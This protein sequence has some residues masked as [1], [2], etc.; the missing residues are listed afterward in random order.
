MDFI[1]YDHFS[2]SFKVHHFPNKTSFKK[3]IHLLRYSFYL[4]LLIFFI[5]INMRESWVYLWLMGWHV[6]VNARLIWGLKNKVIFL[7]V[8]DL[9]K[10]FFLFMIQNRANI[11]VHACIFSWRVT[12]CN[13]Y[14]ASVQNLFLF[15]MDLLWSTT[16]TFLPK[17]K[18]RF[19]FYSLFDS[20]LI[21]ATLFW[22]KTLWLSIL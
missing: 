9:Y 14:I 6:K 13:T 10:G 7:V 8:E 22:Y 12:F 1:Y 20:L 21:M 3:F 4:S 19:I 5:I 2:E 17:D 16:K 15:F 11:G 18:W